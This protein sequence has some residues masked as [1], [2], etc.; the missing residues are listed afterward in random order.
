MLEHLLILTIL[1]LLSAFFSS[2]ELAFVVANRLKIEIK[3]RTKNLAAINADYFIKNTQDFFS[4]ILISNNVINIAFASLSAIYLSIHF[5]LSEYE[6]LIVSTLV[7]LFLG[8]LI[9]KY[10]AREL[11]DRFV[12][13]V[14]IPLRLVSFLLYPLVKP[15]SRL[16][17][18]TM[19]SQQQQADNIY[20]L[21]DKEDVKSLVAESHRAGKVK[22]EEG[23]FISKVFE[24]GDQKIYEALTPRTEIVGLEINQTIDEAISAFIESGFSKLP[25]YED[26]LDNI[27]GVILA[28]DLFTNPSSIKDILRDVQFYPETKKSLEVLNEFLAQ[29]MSIAIVVDEFGG[30]AGVVTVEDIIEELFGEIKDE[31]DVDENI[32]RKI[33]KDSYIISGKVEVDLINEKYHLNIPVGSYE[34]IGGYV[35][36]KIGKIP[37]QGETFLI[38]N[39][40]IL[41]IRADKVRIDLIKLIHKPNE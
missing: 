13:V 4:T 32:C 36:E 39:F 20:Y 29:N 30:T 5:G 27:K 26:N 3:V 18:F 17:D 24:L 22:K 34:T 12:L 33:S 40:Q 25:V 16:S 15:L 6:I 7:L 1:I 14:A 8:E 9:P 41:I 10:F 2:T 35:I 19:K 31:Y 11:A 38:D 23:S 28:K 21:F 37:K